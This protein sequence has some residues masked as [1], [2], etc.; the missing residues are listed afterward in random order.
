MGFDKYFLLNKDF[1]HFKEKYPFL[2]LSTAD[3]NFLTTKAHQGDPCLRI[4]FSFT[5]HDNKSCMN[6]SRFQP[7]ERESSKSFRAENSIR[8]FKVSKWDN[9]GYPLYSKYSGLKNIS[10]LL[11]WGRLMFDGASHHAF[12]YEK[13]VNHSLMLKNLISYLRVIYSTQTANDSW[14]TWK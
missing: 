14:R 8:I 2:C 12:P 13:L 1:D 5:H 4:L 10:S 7:Y 6:I 9:R 11:Y 3:K